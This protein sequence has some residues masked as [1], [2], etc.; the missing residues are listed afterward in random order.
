MAIVTYRGCQYD[1]D[2]HKRDFQ[3]WWNDMHC[4]AT[5]KRMYR[6]QSYRPVSQCPLFGNL[7]KD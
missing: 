3:E 6:G 7:K 1:T 5:L 4:D 2:T